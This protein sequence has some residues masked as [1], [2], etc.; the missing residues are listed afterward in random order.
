V[1]CAGS[2]RVEIG[3]GFKVL[4]GGQFEVHAASHDFVGPQPQ[5]VNVPPFR[6]GKMASTYIHSL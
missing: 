2:T 6:T 5:S 3:D 1:I 4:T